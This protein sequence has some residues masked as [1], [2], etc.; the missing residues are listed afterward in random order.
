MTPVQAPDRAVLRA[1][2]AMVIARKRRAD[3]LNW[4]YR[5][6]CGCERGIYCP[7]GKEHDLNVDAAEGR[8]WTARGR[9]LW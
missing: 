5:R 2:N 1:F 6:G 7:T 9:P 8:Y 4:A 3:H